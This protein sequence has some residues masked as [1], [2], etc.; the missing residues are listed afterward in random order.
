ML[1]RMGRVTCTVPARS[2]GDRIFYSDLF[3][4]A[5]FVGINWGGGS[6]GNSDCEDPAN[7]LQV[8][9]DVCTRGRWGE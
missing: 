2:P 9:I 8:V 1:E 5:K 3:T 7:R 6:D 4:N